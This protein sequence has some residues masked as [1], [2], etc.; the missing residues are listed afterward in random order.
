MKK[1]KEFLK[2]NLHKKTQD[3]LKFSDFFFT[4]MGSFSAHISGK[5]TRTNK[6]IL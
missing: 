2:K 4:F 1:Q 5:E 3:F 6:T